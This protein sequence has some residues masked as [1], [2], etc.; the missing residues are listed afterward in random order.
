MQ[1]FYKFIG[2]K[3]FLKLME[4]KEKLIPE[5]RRKACMDTFGKHVETFSQDWFE[6]FSGM[7]RALELFPSFAIFEID[8]GFSELTTFFLA[9]GM[10]Q[11][12]I[13]IPPSVG[14]F[15]LPEDMFSGKWTATGFAFKQKA[16][17]DHTKLT[18]LSAVE[19]ELCSEYRIVR[20]QARIV[21]YKGGTR[22]SF[23]SAPEHSK[24]SGYRDALHRQK[25]LCAFLS[26][27]VRPGG[28][29][30]LPQAK[31]RIVRMLASR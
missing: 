16:G 15:A 8:M 13:A 17:M 28:T 20:E 11:K 12:M 22:E 24:K 5:N 29:S 21:L 3:E 25:L 1:K 31:S 27:P 10:P 9:S 2:K 19:N 23:W 30:W 7:D 4:E 14:A 18:E 26:V 6:E